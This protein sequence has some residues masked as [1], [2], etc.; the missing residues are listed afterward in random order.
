MALEDFGAVVKEEPSFALAHVEAAKVHT[1]VGN[2][3]EAIRLYQLAVDVSAASKSGSAAQ[4]A[5]ALPRDE[6]DMA[7]RSITRLQAR[8]DSGGGADGGDGLAA[9]GSGRWH[10][11]D[12]VGLSWDTCV[13]Q[14]RASPPI[15]PHP[16]PQHAWHLSASFEGVAREYTPISSAADWENGRVDLLVKT[17]RDGKVSKAFGMLQTLDDAQQAS[18]VNYTSIDDQPCW[19]MLSKPAITLFLPEMIELPPD[20]GPESQRVNRLGIVVGGTGVAPAVQLLRE[21]ADASGPF[22]TECEATLLYSSH[23]SIDVLMVDELRAIVAASAGRVKV[24]F[25]LTAHIDGQDPWET[26]P[27]Q[28]HFRGRHNHF[29]SFFH[30]LRSSRRDARDSGRRRCVPPTH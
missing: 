5:S 20:G 9:D 7:K 26:V 16:F 14:L 11:A 6:L 8:L 25:T 18:Q 10:V 21:V 23:T 3:A 15:E 29:A 24:N 30:A 4:R 22:G 13:S 28:Q 27:P 12:I 2:L 1:F 17:Y 19:V